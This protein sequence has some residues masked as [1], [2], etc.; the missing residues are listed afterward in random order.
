M[1]NM[2]P[3]GAEDSEALKQQLDYAVNYGSEVDEDKAR[4]KEEMKKKK[5]SLFGKAEK[6]RK[7][8]YL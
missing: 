2:A 3:M 5:K 4:E 1:V 8:K 7:W 6:W